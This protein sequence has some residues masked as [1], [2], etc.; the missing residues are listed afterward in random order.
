MLR[1]RWAPENE[2]RIESDVHPLQKPVDP[3]WNPRESIVPSRQL[4]PR[5]AIVVVHLASAQ[6][7]SL[8]EERGKRELPYASLQHPRPLKAEESLLF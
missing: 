4:L 3:H 7:A 5:S 1:R 8:L 6:L 2:K